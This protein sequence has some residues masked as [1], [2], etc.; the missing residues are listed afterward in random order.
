[1]ER[2][3]E[4]QLTKLPFS[5]VRTI[6]N[7]EFLNDTYLIASYMGN[8]LI[9]DKDISWYNVLDYSQQ[10]N[11]NLCLFVGDSKLRYVILGVG[12]S[13]SMYCE[14]RLQQESI[15]HLDQDFFYEYIKESLDKGCISINYV[16]EYIVKRNEEVFMDANFRRRMLCVNFDSTHIEDQIIS[17]CELYRNI[18]E[19]TNI[20]EDKFL[21]T[22]FQSWAYQN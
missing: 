14:S 11:I 9:V 6:T 5:S 21:K 7:G 17:R 22:I 2:I 16:P 20:P 10:I 13:L 3:L 15:F 19:L 4:Q 8:R 1:M 18:I 12:N